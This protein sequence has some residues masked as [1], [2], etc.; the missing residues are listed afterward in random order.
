MSDTDR[1]KRNIDY[2]NI[3]C[4]CNSKMRKSILHNAD[5]DLINTLCECIHNCLNGN[6]DLNEQTKNKLKR[7]KNILRK[8]LVKKKVSI[9]KGNFQSKRRLSTSF[10]INGPRW[11]YKYIS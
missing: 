6:I 2:L 8:L 1:V 7:H 9:K 3:L 5:K 11:S 4:K 10:I